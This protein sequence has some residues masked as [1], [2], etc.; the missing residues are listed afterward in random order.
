MSGR[1]D[2]A[3]KSGGQSGSKSVIRPTTPAS[4]KISSVSEEFMKKTITLLSLHSYFQC[5]I[6]LLVC[7]WLSFSHLWI[8]MINVYGR[9]RL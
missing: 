9:V 3:Q 4:S 1:K 5:D 8:Q 7:L 2:K 6:L